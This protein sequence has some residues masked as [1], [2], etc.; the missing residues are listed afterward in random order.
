MRV[1]EFGDVVGVGLPVVDQL[2]L[3]HQLADSC[4]HHVY[5]HDGASIVLAAHAD[6]LDTPGGPEDL[7]LAVP[8]E[9]VDHGADL[10]VLLLG[11][12]LGEA[13]RGDLRVA[14][15]DLRDAGLVDRCRVEASQLLGNEDPLP[16]AAVSELETGNN[17][18]DRVDAVQVGAQ[19]LVGDDEASV[20]VDPSF[21][22][23]DVRGARATPDSD[24]K[25]VRV[26]RV[27][28]LQAYLHAA[29]VL[30]DAGELDP[31]L[32]GDSA[33][34]E[35]ALKLLG[36]PFVL[37]GRQ[38]RQGLHDGDFGAEGT[39]DAR[40]LHADDAHAEHDDASRDVVHGEG[41]VAGDYL[42]ADLQPGQRSSV[43]AGRQDNCLA[44]GVA[45][46]VHF[47]RLA[48][49]EAARALDDCDLAGLHESLQSLVELRDD[50]VLVRV[51]PVHVDALERGLHAEGL[52]LAGRVGDLGCM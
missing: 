34:A 19:L 21:F 33:L 16:E 36:R 50:A 48:A 15:G 49:D 51:D 3:T 11:L 12:R 28:V 7:A 22:V 6:Q 41:L 26:D 40:E 9:V 30:L 35:G 13:D 27:A 17:V 46:P 10:A 1:N 52:A 24:E 23:P 14:V 31:G 43:R 39:P 44:G 5:P 37:E 20:H 38:P 29:V 32:E 18:A 47:D 2:C 42:A 25:Q 4:A 45:L 8:G